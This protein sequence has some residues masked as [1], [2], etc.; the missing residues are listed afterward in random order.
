MYSKWSRA[1]LPV[2]L[3]HASISFAQQR[4]VDLEVICISPADTV[5]NGIGA[6]LRFEMRNNGP[7]V[8]Y[9][10]DTTL[11]WLY[12][13]EGEQTHWAYSGATI[14]TSDGVIEIGQST[15]YNDNYSIRFPFPERQDTF[16]VDFCVIIGASYIDERGDTISPFSWIDPN[17]DNDM[18]CTPVTVVP[19]S[20]GSTIAGAAYR[21]DLLLYPNPV[22][23]RLHI[24]RS[25]K[26]KNGMLL[27]TVADISG[28]TLL[29]HRFNA[30]SGN[31]DI[32]SLDVA[33]L[34]PGMYQVQIASSEATVSRKI[35]ISR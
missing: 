5:V 14:G 24:R 18:C 26:L 6:V 22:R 10:R 13:T 1:I 31:D 12:V 16:T 7:D 33:M 21:E 34:P 25:D 19:R 30:G 4:T 8:K 20:S 35:V 17:P 9:R 28:R 27:V 29:Q 11:Y 3:L 32:G 23:D 2:L 15:F